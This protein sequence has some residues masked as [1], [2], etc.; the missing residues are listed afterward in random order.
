M[1][2]DDCDWVRALRES[3]SKV[4]IGTI[5]LWDA[6]WLKA[7]NKRRDL[8]GANFAM[9]KSERERFEAIEEMMN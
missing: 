8:Q 2:A 4:A 6:D 5:P 7:L 3:L 1:K 9:S